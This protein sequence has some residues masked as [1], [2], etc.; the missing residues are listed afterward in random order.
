MVARSVQAVT[1]PP[2]IAAEQ[3]LAACHACALLLRV[4]ERAAAPRCARCGANVRVRLPQSLQRTSALLVAAAVCYVPANVLPVLVTTSVGRVYP[5]TILQGVLD[6][7]RSGS[8]AIALIV[9]VASVMVPLGKIGT[10]AGLVWLAAHGGSADRRQ[11]TRLLRLVEFI[12]R[13]SI[14]DVFVDA[15]V[16]GLLQ[17]GPW[18]SARPGPGVPFFA[19]TAVLTMLAASAFDAR[20]LWDAHR[21]EHADVR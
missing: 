9:L 1:A 4:G 8:W 14:L 13:W 17:F 21:V 2:A 5:D 3:G 15:F 10:L 7:C 20:L 11:C 16:V 19:A 12:G 18:I 6:L